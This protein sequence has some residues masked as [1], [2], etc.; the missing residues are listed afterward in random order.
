VEDLDREILVRADIEGGTHAFIA[1]RA[2]CRLGM[3][4]H[5]WA[6]TERGTQ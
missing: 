2:A 1:R 5:C 6:E 4:V 3:L